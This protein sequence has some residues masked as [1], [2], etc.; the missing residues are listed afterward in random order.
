M[1][2]SIKKLEAA[3]AACPPGDDRKRT[4]LLN[5]LG[6]ELVNIDSGRALEISLQ[7]QRLCIGSEAEAER[8]DALNLEALARCNLCDLTRAREICQE[9]FRLH[10]KL[11]GNTGKANVLNTLG[12]IYARLG[13]YA[14][15]L[16]NHLSAL[17]LMQESGDQAGQAEVLNNVGA[18]YELMSDYA[19]GL[20]Y[21]CKSLAIRRLLEDRVG[22]AVSLMNIGGIYEQLGEYKK[23]LECHADSIELFAGS[24]DGRCGSAYN[25]M[26][27]IYLKQGEYQ[28]ALNHYHRALKITEAAGDRQ[29]SI[30][31]MINIGQVSLKMGHPERAEKLFSRSLQAA[32]ASGEKHYQAESL[33]ALGKLL[34]DQ[35]LTEQGFAYIKQ[36]LDIGNELLARTITQRGHQILSQAH[37]QAGEHRQALEHFE[38]FY[39]ISQEMHDEAAERKRQGLTAQFETQQ[40]EH[41]AEVFRLKNVELAKTFQ[42]LR[43]L[44]RSLQEADAQKA[45][46]LNSVNRKNKQLEAMA[47]ED[48]LTGLLNRRSLDL[49]LAKEFS[50]ARRFKKKLMVA[51]AD[52]D[53]FRRINDLH[54]HQA[55][56]AVLKVVAE[57]VC[58]NLRLIDTAARFGGEEFVIVM[59]ETP[60]DGAMLVCERIR[61]EVN[62]YR[63]SKIA[64]GLAVTV[65]IGL[66]GDLSVPDH[67]KMLSAADSGLAKAKRAGRN[68]V[69]G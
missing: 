67:E 12:S 3:V 59:P 36:A 29:A 7:I 65:S 21:Y 48:G 8:A 46:L 69:S 32:T 31:I 38:Q 45:K 24:D 6:M 34:L 63:W 52:I 11:G 60:L 40:A 62:N 37:K 10:E 19:N 18:D 16:V 41:K 33:L 53:H 55:G 54:G 14:K 61:K 35:H 27:E 1:N 47:R 13:E 4:R 2:V 56:D 17:R 22:Q 58:K 68:R 5:Q 43:D 25:N 30:G 26:G 50:K 51:I 44:H 9:A 64:Q 66:T 49:E 23:A 20:E 42:Q 57:L 28:N 15:A 39:R